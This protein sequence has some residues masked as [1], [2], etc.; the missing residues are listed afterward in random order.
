M[1]FWIVDAFTSQPLT[2]NPAAVAVV[3]AFPSD[4][5]MQ[6]MAARFN[7]SETCFLK[8]LD[9]TTYHIRWFTPTTE[10][11][12]CGHATLAA[13]YVLRSQFRVV[14]DRL[15]F[16]SLGGDLII[17]SIPQKIQLS[18][19]LEKL[20]PTALNFEIAAALGESTPIKAATGEYTDSFL[21]YI[22]ASEGRIASLKPDFSALTQAT[23]NALIVTAPGERHAFV[24]RVFT[25]QY[26]VNEDPLT[27]SAQVLLTSY[28]HRCTGANTF[29]S[30]QCSSQS[31]EF[32][33]VYS[34][35]GVMIDGDAVIRAVENVNP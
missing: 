21:L 9:S 26:G 24:Y 14:S 6:S 34:K 25:P 27:G 5:L 7:F 32:N 13:A 23:P 20:Q 4:A 1:K 18:L 8:K 28:W 31:G 35:T 12:L 33:S 17:N 10:I 2:G 3:D 22:Y 15:V 19:P 11:R 29:W 30:K 16:Q